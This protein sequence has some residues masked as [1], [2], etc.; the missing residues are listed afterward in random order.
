MS[1]PIPHAGQAWRIF[2]VEDNAAVRRGI[3]SLVRLEPDLIICGEA[4]D[5]DA[6][7]LRI[8]DLRPNL[9]IVDLSL[10]RSSGLEIIPQL[11][12]ECPLV[13]I[14]V[15]SMHD[16]PPWIELALLAGAHGYLTKEESPDQL[17][18]AI[19]RVLDGEQFLSERIVARLGARG[20]SDGLRAGRTG[21]AGVTVI[22]QPPHA[23]PAS[24]DPRRAPP[25]PLPPRDG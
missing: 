4:E 2:L 21:D 25:R 3:H 18:R 1:T 16:Q 5:A 14:L 12:V 24:P 22:P 20:G 23:S 9:A 19:R 11:R 17:I 6:A 10:K 15:L 8:R 7:F 13:R